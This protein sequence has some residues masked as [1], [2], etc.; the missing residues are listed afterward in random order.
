MR[1]FADV[2]L[3]NHPLLPPSER[4]PC[5]TAYHGGGMAAVGTVSIDTRAFSSDN[6]VITK[7]ETT[8]KRSGDHSNGQLS[9]ELS[10]TP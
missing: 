4:R 5:N 7:D 2:A 1:G 3:V 8:T 10:F 6:D 9:V